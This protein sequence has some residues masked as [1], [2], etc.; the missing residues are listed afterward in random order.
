MSQQVGLWLRA[1]RRHLGWD[2]PEMDRQLA[3]GAG[4][5]RDALPGMDS[6][7]SYVRCWERNGCEI[8]ERYMLL[9]CAALGIAPGGFG[10]G[11]VSAGK[12]PCPT[13]Q[14]GTRRSATQR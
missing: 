11:T 3:K 9:Y 6:L 13:L 8:S 14:P 5:D 12:Q 10:S 4:S 2:V 1:R 7:V